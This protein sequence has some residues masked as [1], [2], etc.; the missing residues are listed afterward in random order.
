MGMP[1]P[2]P[3]PGPGEKRSSRAQ[4]RN[5]DE[6]RAIGDAEADPMLEELAHNHG[7]MAIAA[8]LDRLLRWDPAGSFPDAS[9]ELPQAVIDKAREF[10]HKPG[11]LDGAVEGEIDR[12]RIGKAQ[13]LFSRYLHSGL[14]VLGCASLPACYAFP[15][16]ALV[17]MGSG[18]LSVQV[19]RRLEDTIAFLT[20]VMSPGALDPSG[21]DGRSGPG[22]LWIRKVRLMHALM[23]CLTQA[24]PK[25]VGVSLAL[26]KPSH[27]LLNLDWKAESKLQGME[28]LMPIDQVELGFVLLTFSWLLVRG[29]DILRIPMSEEE[30]DNHI[31]A[32]AVIGHGLGIDKSLRPLTAKDARDLFDQLESRYVQ[33]THQGR[34]LVA[35]LVVYIIIRQYDAINEK[36]AGLR[37]SWARVLLR[38]PWVQ[39]LVAWAK[40]FAK[41]C[42]ESLARTLVRELAGQ[43]VAGMLWVPRAPFIHWAVGK[44]F[45]IAMSAL[46]YKG[47]EWLMVQFRRRETGLPLAIGRQLEARR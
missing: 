27:F 32:W 39:D 25:T 15:G 11:V 38:R 2:A 37:K 16:V 46:E 41:A 23:R 7:I 43:R 5:L 1:E 19:Q 35:A 9:A 10:L 30:M 18:R 12:R 36:L 31:Y 47:R 13:M 34:L 33:G 22:T 17:L 45:R 42:L 44:L 26:E 4:P 29:F 6:L 8:L 20:M 24:D 40:P 28:D 21:E 3:D 14:I